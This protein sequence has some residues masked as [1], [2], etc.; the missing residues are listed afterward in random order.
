M[1]EIVYALVNDGFIVNTIKADHE[2]AE[3]IAPQHDSVINIT[4]VS[5]RPSI[6]WAWDGN[7]FTDPSNQDVE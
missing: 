6:G 1:S 7:S 3:L 5:P 4:E 2:F